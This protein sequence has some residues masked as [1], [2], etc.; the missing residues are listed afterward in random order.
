[1]PL[2]G[3][4]V[5]HLLCCSPEK[6][7]KGLIKLKRKLMLLPDTTQFAFGVGPSRATDRPQ[8]GT[9]WAPAGQIEQ[10]R[11]RAVQT[12]P[13]LGPSWARTGQR[14]GTDWVT[15]GQAQGNGLGPDWARA[16][17]RLGTRWAPAGHGL[18][19]CF[20]G[21]RLY[22]NTR[23]HDGTVSYDLLPGISSGCAP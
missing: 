4:R 13:H 5:T 11:G 15:D 12:G 17:P 3:G 19:K 22:R 23:S 7:L 14:M 9:G 16:G 2:R 18:G 1:M 20:Y 10:R 21:C 6:T 8:L